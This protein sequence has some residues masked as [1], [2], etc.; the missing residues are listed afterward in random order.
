MGRGAEVRARQ[1]L[2]Q[3]G[4]SCV[5]TNYRCQVGEL[6]LI[7]REGSTIVF[8]EVRYRKNRR[9]GGAL[10][11]IDAHKRRKL[12][13]AAEHYL[14]RRRTGDVPCRLDVVLIT[15]GDPEDAGHT[16]RRVRIEWIRDA[17]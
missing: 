4:L 16:D 6:D 15:G 1:Y 9:Y 3:R 17:C 13:A 2:Q 7:M 12:R 10:E 5:E 11:S 8:V 14:Q